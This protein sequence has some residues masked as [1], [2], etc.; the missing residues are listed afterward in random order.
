MGERR[1][2][3]RYK[4]IRGH[5][6]AYQRWMG[7]HT[8]DDGN[9][10]ET[11]KANPDQLPFTEPDSPT[12]QQRLLYK[13]AQTLHGQQAKV[14]QRYMREELSQEEIA[15][16]LEISQQAVSKLLERAIE[17]VTEEFN[18]LWALEQKKGEKDADR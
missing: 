13:A 12:V 6:N 9:A 17:R 1:I 14:Y 16:E 7:R 2:F 8:D 15:V 10:K 5:D 18:R 3:P 4:E 11:W